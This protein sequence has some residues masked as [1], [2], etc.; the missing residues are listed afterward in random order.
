MSTTYPNDIMPFGVSGRVENGDVLPLDQYRTDPQRL[1]G[2]QP[3]IARQAL[4]NTVLRQVSHMAAGLA[5]Y[6][7]NRYPGG[8][9]DDGDL[10]A[11]ETGL[12]SALAA[13]L[14]WHDKADYGPPALAVGDDGNLYRC[15]AASGPQT[16]AGGKIVGAK[17]PTANADYWTRLPNMTDVLNTP[18]ATTAHAGHVKPGAGTGVDAAGALSVRYGSAAGTACQ[19]N[20]ARLSNARPPT[21]HKATH[22]TGGADALTPADIGAAASTIAITAG[23]GLSGGGNL[24]ANR[25][26]AVKY[27]TT[28]GTACQGNDPRLDA[29]KAPIAHA[30]SHAAG[31]SDPLTPTA[32]GAA[33][34]TVTITAGNGLSGGGKLTGNVTLAAKLLDSVASTDITS[35]GTANAVKV[36]YDT[37]VNAL[38]V[39]SSAQ[40]VSG[41]RAPMPVAYEGVGQF[42]AIRGAFLNVYTP[43]A[44]PAGGTWLVW[45]T[46]MQYVQYVPVYGGQST[47]MAI[48]AGGTATAWLGWAWRIA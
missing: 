20:D 44:L 41:A 21:A 3:G 34:N 42:V 23:A 11:V 29:S 36:A 37:A 8:V 45:Y 13:G 9:K 12:L 19:G 38:N 48:V 17:D 10:A 25:T 4:E 1:V 6:I 39:A 24:T 35:A 14:L 5:Q 7:A 28:A 47:G 2:H 15:D 18:L 30:A 46:D 27:G 32:I 40:T 16:T 26:L 33:A 22:K 31:G 43:A